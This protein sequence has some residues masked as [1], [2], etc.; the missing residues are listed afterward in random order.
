MQMTHSTYFDL[1]PDFDGLLEVTK[2]A[3]IWIKPYI[4]LAVDTLFHL[5]RS[6]EIDDAVAVVSLDWFQPLS[7]P[8]FGRPPR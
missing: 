5:R 2:N 4:E 6:P 7:E 3:G 8:V 1:I